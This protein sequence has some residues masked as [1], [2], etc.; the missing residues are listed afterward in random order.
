MTQIEDIVT[1]GK[2][3]IDKDVKNS[4]QI[5]QKN[6]SQ[7]HFMEIDSVFYEITMLFVF[8]NSFYDIICC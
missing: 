5:K 6:Q 2:I 4:L 3:S 7:I 8:F 1:I